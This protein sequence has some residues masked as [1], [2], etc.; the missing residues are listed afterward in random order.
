MPIIVDKE[1]MKLKIL[2]AFERCIEN[3]PMTNISLRDIAQEAGM[4]HP[5]LLNYFKNKDEL[6]VSYC[7]YTRTFMSEKCAAWFMEHDREQYESNLAYLNDFMSYVANGKEGEI[8]PNATTQTYVL[9]H[10]NGDVGQLVT[11]EFKEWRLL[12]EQCLIKIYG[13]KAGAKEA[14]AMMILISGTFICNYNNALTGKINDNIIGYLSNLAESWNVIMKKITYLYIPYC[15]YCL[16]ANRVMEE[17]VSKKPEYANIEFEKI[18]EYDNPDIADRYDYYYTP[19]MFIDN[20]KVYESH[21]GER[22]TECRIK[23]ENVLELACNW[24]YNKL[25]YKNNDLNQ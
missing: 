25:I 9:G 17:L 15:P 16:Q 5:S 10:Y 24:V 14:E 22:E 19:A 6:I 7:E 13:D 3:K 12:M 1:K 18:S 8:R 21:P 2:A 4:S 23:I 20:K 11:N